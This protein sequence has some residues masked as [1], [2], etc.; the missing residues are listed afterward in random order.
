[1]IPKCIHYCWFGGKP[2][3]PLAIKCIESWKHYFPDYEIIEWNEE[4]YDVES[5]AYTRE[6]YNTKKYAFVSDYARFD[7]LYRFG[8]I[9]FDTDVEVIKSF[10]SIIIKGPFAGMENNMKSICQAIVNPGLCI[11]AEAG[12]P[13]YKEILD[14]YSSIHF[15]KADGSFLQKTVCEHVSEIMVQKGLKPENK[16]QLIAGINIYPA[17]FFNPIDFVSKKLKITENTH[18]IHWYMASWKDVSLIERLKSVVYSILPEKVIRLYKKM[19]TR[20]SK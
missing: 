9:Y 16:L 19:K 13:I 20:H 10:D 15:T 1:M 18:S 3:P 17:D 5:V 2:L 7:I 4:N 12:M 14:Y 11:G 8:G 6:A